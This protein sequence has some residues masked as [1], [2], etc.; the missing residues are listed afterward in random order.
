MVARRGEIPARPDP[1]DPAQSGAVMKQA[2]RGAGGLDGEA[3]LAGGGTPAQSGKK[4]VGPAGKGADWP[5]RVRRA[6]A[7]LGKELTGPA[8]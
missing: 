1:P 8:G 2:R 3:G 7:Q 4:S 5:S 6:P